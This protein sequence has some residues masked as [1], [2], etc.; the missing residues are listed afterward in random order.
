MPKYTA[1]RIQGG[2]ITGIGE[3]EAEDKYTA[4]REAHE[5]LD[6]MKG[7]WAEVTP[8]PVRRKEPTH[9]HP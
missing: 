1:R 9:E 4:Y 5:G 6:V 3:L 2:R 8:V 7:E